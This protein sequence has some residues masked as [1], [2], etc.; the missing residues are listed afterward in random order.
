MKGVG[1]HLDELAEVYSLVCDVV[2][3][4]LVAVSLILHVAYLHVQ[5]EVFCYLSALYHG[6]LFAALRLVVAVHVGV[7]GEAVEFADVVGRLQ[8]SL[9]Y[10]QVHEASRE[11]Y[12]ADVVA[13]I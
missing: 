3:D 12:D 10:L 7:L 9:L 6:S 1:K 2:E 8:V 5:S 4:G 11:G 13:G